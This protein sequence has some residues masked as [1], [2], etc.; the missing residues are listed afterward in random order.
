MT[1][2]INDSNVQSDLREH[3]EQKLK[4]R[5]AFFKKVEDRS[6]SF[7]WWGGV[8]VLVAMLAWVINWI[9]YG[10]PPGPYF[11]ITVLVAMVLLFG[12]PV[13]TFL[14]IQWGAKLISKRSG[15]SLIAQL[16]ELVMSRN[17]EIKEAQRKR[18]LELDGAKREREFA[19]KKDKEERQVRHAEIKKRQKEIQRELQQL[20]RNSGADDPVEVVKLHETGYFKWDPQGQCWCVD[21]ALLSNEKRLS[22]LEKEFGINIDW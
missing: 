12:V 10:A 7:G 2:L 4:S 17:N 16:D 5:V 1:N 9:M 20:L 19:S 18:A 11:I 13:V 14:V 6:E 3:I 21:E 8:L 22:K 15:Q